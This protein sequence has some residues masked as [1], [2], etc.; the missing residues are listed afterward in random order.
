MTISKEALDRLHKEISE[1]ETRTNAL[2]AFMRTEKFVSLETIEQRDLT[3][4]LQCMR[5]YL[6]VLYRRNNRYIDQGN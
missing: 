1:V 2:N 3:D 4:Q 6:K 5:G